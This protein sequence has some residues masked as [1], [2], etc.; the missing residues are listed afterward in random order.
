[1]C[2]FTLILIWMISLF[3]VNRNPIELI[4]AVFIDLFGDPHSFYAP[5]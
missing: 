5:A 4:K 1:M 2:T 3:L